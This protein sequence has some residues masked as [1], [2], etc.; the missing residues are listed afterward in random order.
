[1]AQD[2]QLLTRY[3]LEVE[4][5]FPPELI[6]LL[7]H[8]LERVFSEGT[9]SKFP[10]TQDR[11]HAG[12][13]GTTNDLRD[14]WFAG[15]SDNHLAVVWLGRDDNKPV[16]LTGS[17]GALTVWGKVMDAIETAAGERAE[18]ANINWIRIDTDTLQTTSILNRNSTMLPF[19]AGS[20]PAEVKTR[21]VIDTAPVKNGA[22]K[23][24]DSLNNLFN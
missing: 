24:F 19:V 4:Q 6:F 3:G 22:R 9:A 23:F 11:F 21:P 7:T 18:P 5:R 13:T 10:F 15:F 16:S 12:K 17:S 20:E 8:A 14:S 1:M 2:N